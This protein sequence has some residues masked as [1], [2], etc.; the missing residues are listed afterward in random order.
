MPL[1]EQSLAL[2]GEAEILRHE[3]DR[4]GFPSVRTAAR[5]ISDNSLNAALRLLGY[6][7]EQ[8]MAHSF[9]ATATTLLN[10][11]GKWLPDAIERA[12]AHAEN[13]TVLAAYI[14]EW[15]FR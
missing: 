4:W 2:L 14:E 11:S 5:P 13:D 7:K 8:V 12:L 6:S 3:G 1:S 15:S 10:E 9:R